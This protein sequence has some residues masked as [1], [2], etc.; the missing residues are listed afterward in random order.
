MRVT[1]FLR[2]GF[3]AAHGDDTRGVDQAHT[4]AHHVVNEVGRAVAV[5]GDIRLDLGADG[6]TDGGLVIPVAVAHA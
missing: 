4:L 3:E 6:V 2:S 1:P 5:P